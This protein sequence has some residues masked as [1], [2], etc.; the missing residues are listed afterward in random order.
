MSSDSTTTLPSSFRAAT[1]KTKY[2]SRPS[3]S[4]IRCKLKCIQQYTPVYSTLWHSKMGVILSGSIVPPVV[5]YSAETP[6]SKHGSM[7]TRMTQVTH[8]TR[9]KTATVCNHPVM[10]CHGRL[11][12]TD[13]LL[14]PLKSNRNMCLNKMT[15]LFTPRLISSAWNNLLEK[16][17]WNCLWVNIFQTMYTNSCRHLTR[18]TTK[19]TPDAYLWSTQVMHQKWTT[20]VS[21][22]SNVSCTWLNSIKECVTTR[23]LNSGVSCS[24]L[25][26]ILWVFYIG[27]YQIPGRVLLAL[28]LNNHSAPELPFKG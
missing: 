10:H 28:R 4:P 6:K 23:A 12:N 21:L 27:S 18:S 1:M 26:K 8:T 11:V 5:V 9:S 7:A 19:T 16:S 20:Y 15:L 13:L 17:R 25:N 22:Y 24:S 2:S 3:L 14:H